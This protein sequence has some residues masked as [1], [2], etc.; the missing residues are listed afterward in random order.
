MDIELATVALGALAQRTRLE[1][2]RLLVRTE[3][4]G[5]AA[6]DAARALA[7][8]VFE[9]LWIP[10]VPVAL[11]RLATRRGPLRFAKMPHRSL[12]FTDPS[13][14]RPATDPHI[15]DGGLVAIASGSARQ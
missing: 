7:V 15:G 10:V 11:W 4:E 6:G 13:T 12:P 14:R 9:S 5:M 1:T 3:P 8:A 2:F